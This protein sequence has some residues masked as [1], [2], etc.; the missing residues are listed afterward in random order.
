M[1]TATS[2]DF[3]YGMVF[4]KPCRLWAEDRDVLIAISSSGRSENIL[5]AVQTCLGAGCRI[6]TFSGFDPDNPLRKL[7]H[8][9]FYVPS[10]T[11]GYVE[12]VHNAL[13]HMVTDFVLRHQWPGLAVSEHLLLAPGQPA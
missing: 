4:E 8:L 10:S 1:V 3:G 13:A 12:V 5:R 6:L 2:N 9:N 7:G 11:Y